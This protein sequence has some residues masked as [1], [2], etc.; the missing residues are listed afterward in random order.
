LVGVLAMPLAAHAL[1]PAYTLI[2]RG[3]II[4]DGSGAA[5]F[6]GDVAVRGERIA[7]IARH[8]SGSATR[9]ID[10]RGRAVAPGFINMLAHVQQSLLIDGRAQSDLRQGVTLEVM[11]ESSAGPLSPAMKAR[12]EAR[13]AQLKLAIDWTTLGGYLAKFEHQNIS[14]NVA[15]FVGANTI[16][17]YVLDEAN[18]QPTPVQLAEMSRLVRE[19]MEEGALGVTTALIYAPDTYART[20]ELTALATESARCGGM[21]IAHMRSEGDRIIEGVQETID[22]AR[23]S[24]APAEIYHLKVAGKENWGKL[25][26][27]VAMVEAARTAGVRITADMYTYTAGASGLDA[28][29][30][31]WVQD[32]GQEAWIGRLKDPAIRARVI[33]DMRDPHPDWENLMRKSGPD[34]TLLLAVKT[35]ALKPLIGRTIAQIAAT[36]GQSPEEAAIDLVIEDGGRVGVAYFSMSEDN[37]RRQLRLPWVSFGSD[38]DAPS[39][40]GIFLAMGYHPRSFG[41]FARLLGRYVREERQISLQ[42]AVRRLSSL[43]AGNLSLEDRGRLRAGYF[44]DIVIFDPATIA[45]HATF[46]QPRQYSTGVEHVLVN[47]ELA[48]ENGEPTSAR[49]G[50][51]IRGRAWTGAPGGGCRATAHDWR[52]QR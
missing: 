23:G 41:N 31:P 28:S 16:R 47:G 20:P 26:R 5:P 38:A 25:D 39:L 46:E 8:V 2:V 49:P 11:G 21:Y 34:G 51:V 6:V 29:M 7:R 50:R 43:P 10:A 18:V 35:D 22:I 40:E 44:A 30:P 12:L 45:D 52:W 42:E 36:R 32:G 33:A 37:V 19:A 3:G 24:G 9:E 1:P 27:V 4:Y 15:A 13:L 17:T 14:V 48:L